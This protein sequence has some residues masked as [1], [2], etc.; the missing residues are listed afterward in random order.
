MLPALFLYPRIDRSGKALF[1]EQEKKKGFKPL[2][3]T[4]YAETCLEL[5]GYADTAKNLP[6]LGKAGPGN[7]EAWVGISLWKLEL[8]KRGGPSTGLG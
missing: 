1:L 7:L 2:N 3:S 5:R 8:E 6:T 4:A